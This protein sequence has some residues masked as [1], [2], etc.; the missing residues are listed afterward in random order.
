MMQVCLSVMLPDADAAKLRAM[1]V[2]SGTVF[3]AM[4]QSV[5]FEKTGM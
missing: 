4:L 1:T 3:A 5:P 2:E